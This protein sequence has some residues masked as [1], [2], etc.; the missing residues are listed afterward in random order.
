MCLR[1]AVMHESV[2]MESVTVMMRRFMCFLSTYS[3]IHLTIVD[4]G[5][6]VVY[7]LDTFSF[8]KAFYLD[9]II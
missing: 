1:N 7:R 8:N 6:I 9:T 4:A 2:V 5:V 3:G